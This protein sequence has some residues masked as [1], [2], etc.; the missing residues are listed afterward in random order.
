MEERRDSSRSGFNLRVKLTP[1]GDR[2]IDLLRAN[3]GRGGLGGY[4]R[5]PVEA[6]T[7]VMIEIRFEQRSGEAVSE[8]IPGRI[9]WTRRDGNFNAFGAGFPAIR[10]ET[11]PQ[12][13]SYLQYIDQMD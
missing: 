13:Y 6:G 2:P 9:L 3:I 1:K 8:N 10:A 7:E 11:H 5:D 12:L 4:T